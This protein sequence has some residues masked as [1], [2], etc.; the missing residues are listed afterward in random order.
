MP[1]YQVTPLAKNA[2]A[3]AGAVREHIDEGDYY[4]LANSAGWLVKFKGTTVELSH[5]LGITSP[6]LPPAPST[7]GSTMVVAITSYYGRG[8]TDM[9]EWLKTRF[10]AG[11]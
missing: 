5:K 4:E 3:I 9:W 8:P 11:A 1:I 6:A 7:L 10:E 2:P